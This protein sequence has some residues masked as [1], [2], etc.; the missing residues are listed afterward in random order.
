MKP[1]REFQSTF[2]CFL[3]QIKILLELKQS[4][5]MAIEQKNRKSHLH[6]KE[7]FD[8]KDSC[9]SSVQC[10]LSAVATDIPGTITPPMTSVAVNTG[11][12]LFLQGKYD[13]HGQNDDE[14]AVEEVK[15][16][17]EGDQDRIESF[18]WSRELD[19]RKKSAG[20]ACCCQCKR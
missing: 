1:Y 17:R 12:S 11:N 16:V 9:N 2:S 15:E 5:E 7:K 14:G 4:E 13:S 19:N 8:A 18:K 20:C 6:S 3:F 10:N